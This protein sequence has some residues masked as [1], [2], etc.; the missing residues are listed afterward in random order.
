MG[1][2]IS[3]AMLEEIYQHGEEAFPFECCGALVGLAGNPSTVVKIV[4]LT[5]V[6]ETNPRRRYEIDPLEL[7]KVD[8]EVEEQGYEI[9]GIYHSHPDHPARPSEFDRTHAWPN[10]SYMV[11]SV[12]RGKATRITSW[13]LS[14]SHV[15]Q[16]EDMIILE[17]EVMS[18]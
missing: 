1:I 18:Q 9:I 2:K 7:A 16:E 8:R 4:R 6:N 10:W 3:K 15:F 17:S 14:S 5:N 11:L 12:M 13:R